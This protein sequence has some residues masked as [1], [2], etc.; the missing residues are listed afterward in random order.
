MTSTNRLGPG[1]SQRDIRRWA[2]SGLGIWF[3]TYLRDS[4]RHHGLVPGYCTLPKTL[5]LSIDPSKWP[6]EPLPAVLIV[7]AGTQEGPVRQADF[8]WDSEYQ[9][10]FQAVT[11]GPDQ[12]EAELQAS[13]Y[14][15]ALK[16]M[17]LQQSSEW[18]GEAAYAGPDVEVSSVVLLDEDW[19]GTLA[20]SRRRTLAYGA[21]TFSVVFRN[22]ATSR[23]PEIDPLPAPEDDP[24]QFPEIV[25]V[26][27]QTTREAI[28]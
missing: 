18:H 12:D 9:I 5:R 10:S 23:N 24:G 16:Q 19:T 4:E 28:A 25:A 13:I 15:L 8:T 14:G 21:V 1:L 27:L 11:H 17:V 2:V 26:E 3:P 7:T 6:E 20:S 22:T